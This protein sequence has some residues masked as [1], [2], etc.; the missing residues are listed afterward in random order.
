MMM[1]YS[2]STTDYYFYRCFQ[3]AFI[4]F[5]A[6]HSKWIFHHVYP[7]RRVDIIFILS[8]FFFLNY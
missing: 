5:F 4:I 3:M 6:G 7:R 8:I 1:E 2:S